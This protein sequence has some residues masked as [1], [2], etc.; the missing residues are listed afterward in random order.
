MNRKIASLIDAI[1]EGLRGA[2]LQDRLDELAQRRD[3]LV[4][5]LAAPAP[6]PVRLHPNLG[7]VYRRKVEELDAALRDPLIHDEA[8]EI[9][10]GLIE[11]LVDPSGEAAD[12]EV[13]L[14]GEIA[15]MVELGAGTERK[16]AALDERTACSV[17]VVAGTGFEPVTFR[18]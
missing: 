15:R 14:V 10:R 2:D 17:K 4:D 1:S 11:R 6:S 3:A 13:E 18:L 12:F 5:E 7:E 16:K 9:V 8:V